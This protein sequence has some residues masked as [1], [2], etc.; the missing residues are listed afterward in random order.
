MY[1]C[2]ACTNLFLAKKTLFEEEVETKVLY[3]HNCKKLLPC[4]TVI[5]SSGIPKLDKP[6]FKKFIRQG[7][8]E[9]IDRWDDADFQE[10]KAWIRQTAGFSSKQNLK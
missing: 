10:E 7:A 6:A 5:K 2:L 4:V 8:I 9:M 3:C 1:Y